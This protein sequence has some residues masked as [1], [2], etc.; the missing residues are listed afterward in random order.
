MKRAA[1]AAAS[2]RA[3]LP[4]LLLA[5]GH[6]RPAGAVPGESGLLLHHQDLDLL[7]QRAANATVPL[8]VD[9]DSIEGLSPD[10]DAARFLAVRLGIKG[11]IT[12][13]AGVAGAIADHGWLS[14]LRVFAFDSTGLE[15][16]LAG[17][18]RGEGVGTAISP[19]IALPYLAPE[20]V[21]G[22]PRPV[23]AYGLVR[24]QGDADGCWRAGADSVAV[25]PGPD[26]AGI[27]AALLTS[28]AAGPRT[29][30]S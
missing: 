18:L 19:G 28:G 9:L 12:R 2:V 27:R 30:D 11:M 17:H 23:L 8:I 7:L 5:A 15:R 6:E 26:Q 24:T 4:R 25:D 10:E 1:P 16:S 13:H 29:V 22:L 14:L 21:E 3:P 20:D